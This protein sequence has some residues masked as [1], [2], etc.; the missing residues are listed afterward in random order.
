[1]VA[2][3]GVLFPLTAMPGLI[4]PAN[5]LAGVAAS[6]SGAAPTHAAS[7]EAPYNNGATGYLPD[8]FQ[9]EHWDERPAPEQF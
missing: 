1:M 7:S 5:E 6:V 2:I 4:G 9:V 8:R 3:L